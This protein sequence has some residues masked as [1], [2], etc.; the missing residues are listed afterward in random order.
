MNLDDLTLLEPVE[1]QQV[2]NNLKARFLSDKIYSTIGDVVIALNPYKTIDLYG[3]EYVDKYRGRNLY[4]M[5]A[6]M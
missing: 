4:E 6:H 3:P 5:P 2:L 1:E